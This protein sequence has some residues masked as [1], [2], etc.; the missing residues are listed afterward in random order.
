MQIP[1]R[2]SSP[3]GI[4]YYDA[5]C[6]MCSKS[7]QFIRKIDKKQKLQL[8]PINLYPLYNTAPKNTLIFITKQNRIFYY[9]TAVIQFLFAIGGIY[10]LSLLGYGMPKFLRDALYKLIAR[11]RKRF[12]KYTTC[13]L[14][15]NNK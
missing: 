4:L 9:S 11:N 5:H 1:S 15:L 13:S 7:V 2:N 3:K 8:L 14:P 12:F 6:L 10:K